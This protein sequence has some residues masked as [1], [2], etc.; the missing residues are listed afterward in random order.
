MSI[1]FAA[2]TRHVPFFQAL[3]TLLA[4]LGIAAPV[5][6]LS[7]PYNTNGEEPSP[8]AWGEHVETCLREATEA[9]VTILYVAEGEQ[10]FGAI[11]EA[12]AALAAG[13][14]VYLIAPH[15]WQFL[16]NHKNVRSFDS[17]ADAIEAIVSQ[18]KGERARR[19]AT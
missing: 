4:E 14:W 12:F 13:R 9:D 18:A 19:E 3:Q 8:E 17:L 11:G 10:H 16:R 7:W 5:S 1:Y 6:W 15:A 2:K